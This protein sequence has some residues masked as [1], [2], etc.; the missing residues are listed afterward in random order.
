[1]TSETEDDITD[2]D[3]GSAALT[4]QESI[5]HFS[6]EEV[7]YA[8]LVTEIVAPIISSLARALSPRTEVLLHDLTQV[9]NSIV[10]I[11]QPI[12]GRS[13]GGPPTDLGLL[14]FAGGR[15]EDMIGYKTEAAGSV[16]RSSSMFFRT[17]SGRAV[18]CLCINA[19]ISELLRIQQ[20][21]STMT[22]MDA[23]E[24]DGPKETF[25]DS[26]ETLADGVLEQAVQSVGIP[27]HLMK[28]PHKVTVVKELERRGFFA[29][30][31]SV[32]LA[33]KRLDVT[34]YTIYNYLNELQAD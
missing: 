9:P 32:D 20:F 34:R 2:A 31:E 8:R 18:A 22:A 13:V 14:T 17:R 1:M 15:V 6:A 19:E 23:D 7:A 21:I 29:L 10:A 11:A 30:K 28:K 24:A 4:R 26:V 27:V 25:P 33:A 16:M 12:T 5:L 3:F